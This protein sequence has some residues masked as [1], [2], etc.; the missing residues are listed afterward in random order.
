ML[1]LLLIFNIIF[2][3][4]SEV[5]KIFNIFINIPELLL[6]VYKIL[7]NQCQLLS[8]KSVLF[9]FHLFLYANFQFLH[10]L[11]DLFSLN[12]LFFNNIFPP[13]F[14]DVFDFFKHHGEILKKLFNLI[15]I[16]LLLGITSLHD[17]INGVHVNQLLLLW[18]KLYPTLK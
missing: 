16:Q 17:M 7:W 4:V 9:L 18:N 15:N 13:S 10:F 5:H 14:F 1:F 3:L 11:V 6:M 2:Y 8:F 12:I